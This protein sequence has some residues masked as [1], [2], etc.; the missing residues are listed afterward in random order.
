MLRT[1]SLKGCLYCCETTTENILPQGRHI[2]YNG[3]HKQWDKKIIALESWVFCSVVSHNS[4]ARRFLQ[5][6]ILK[7]FKKSVMVS[8]FYGITNNALLNN[9]IIMFFLLSVFVH[10]LI[11]HKLK[12]CVCDGEEKV[13]E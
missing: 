2:C 9:W 13:M 3:V 8:S 4:M 5:Q 11:P 7:D 12:N 10:K 6:A 1:A